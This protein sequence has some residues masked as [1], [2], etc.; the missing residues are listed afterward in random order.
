MTGRVGSLLVLVSFVGA[1]ATCATRRSGEGVSVPSTSAFAP[2]L[3]STNKVCQLT[4]AQDRGG[5]GT[6]G[7]TTGMQLGGGSVGVTGT[8]VGWSFEHAGLLQFMFGDT[9]DF[10]PDK[11]NPAACGTKADPHPS[12]PVPLDRWDTGA[13]YV[14]WLDTH[15][16]S[17][18]SWATAPLTSNPNNC[19]PTLVRVADE[20]KEGSA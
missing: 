13:D 9:R 2:V 14:N 3:V 19:I 16:N 1:A 6:A 10:S 18:D 12:A 7:A 11:C 5:T 4:G 15:G 17:P 20:Q 8:D